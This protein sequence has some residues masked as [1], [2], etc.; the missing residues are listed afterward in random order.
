MTKTGESH[1]IWQGNAGCKVVIGYAAGLYDLFH[2]GHLRALEAAKGMCDMLI[3]GVI[4]DDVAEEYKGERPVI[5][6][7][8]RREIISSLKCVDAVI[9]CRTRDFYKQWLL[10]KFDVAFS[11]ED[12]ADDPLYMGWEKKLREREVALK[13]FPRSGGISSSKI[14]D[15]IRGK[16]C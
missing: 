1:Q 11:G 15:K 14:K 13:F 10:F 7:H 16:E 12:W 2:V 5:P 3:V 9:E 4:T 8:Q 6:F